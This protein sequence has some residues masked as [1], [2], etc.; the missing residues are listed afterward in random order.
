MD[1]NLFC[2]I[3][4]NSYFILKFVM[5]AEGHEDIDYEED[6]TKL[7]RVWD[8]IKQPNKKMAKTSDARQTATQTKILNESNAK[9]SRE[10]KSKVIVSQQNLKKT[11]RNPKSKPDEVI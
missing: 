1:S 7:K 9:Q 8:E 5:S 4:N 11:V 10:K 3:L 2:V 6:V